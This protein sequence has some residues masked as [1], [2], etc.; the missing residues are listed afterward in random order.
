M[1]YE[2]LYQ[3]CLFCV[4]EKKPWICEHCLSD[5]GVWTRYEVVDDVK[6]LIKIV[7]NNCNKTCQYIPDSIE[8]PICE[9][10]GPLLKL[11]GYKCTN[12]GSKYG[13]NA[14]NYCPNCGAKIIKD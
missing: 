7:K 2:D 1:K 12:C 5:E 10:T 6:N 14:Y 4:N 13:T 8:I 11:A 3:S 9:N